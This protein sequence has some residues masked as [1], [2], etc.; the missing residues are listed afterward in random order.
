MISHGSA[1]CFYCGVKAYKWKPKG[2]DLMPDDA[3]TRDHIVPDSKARLLKK[4][5][6]WNQSNRVESCW[7]CN[8]YKGHLRPLDWLVIMPSNEGATR[9]GERL[10]LLGCS[11]DEVSEAMGRRKKT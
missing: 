10:I 11:I 3:L 7:A 2:K 4:S 6:A 5:P 9:L 1:P 8:S